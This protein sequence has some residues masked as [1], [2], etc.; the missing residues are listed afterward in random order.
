MPGKEVLKETVFL[1]EMSTVQI[2]GGKKQKV[3][4]GDILGALTA[5]KSIAAQDIGKI[6]I[7]DNSTYVAVKRSIAKQAHDTLRDGKIKGRQFQARLLNN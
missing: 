4:A 3:R 1:A 6:N 5:N 2:D 7:F